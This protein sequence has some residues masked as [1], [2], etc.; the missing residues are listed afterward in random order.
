MVGLDVLEKEAE[1]PTEGVAAS[2]WLMGGLPVTFTWAVSMP[3][4]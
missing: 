1:R 4:P 2:A 3:P